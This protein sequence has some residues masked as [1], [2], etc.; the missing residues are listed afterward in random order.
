MDSKIKYLLAENDR[1]WRKVMNKEKSKVTEPD[2]STENSGADN[3]AEQSKE[4][5]SN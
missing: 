4:D 3:G 1:D 2:N 5:K